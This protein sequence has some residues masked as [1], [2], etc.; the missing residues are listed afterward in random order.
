VYNVYMRRNA[1]SVSTHVQ[2]DFSYR[3]SRVKTNTKQKV[4]R[5]LTLQSRAK[6]FAHIRDLALQ[7]Q[8]IAIELHHPLNTNP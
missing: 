6:A 5:D 8:V 1:Y 4:L 2:R 7:S 3:K